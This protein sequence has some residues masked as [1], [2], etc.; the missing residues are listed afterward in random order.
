MTPSTRL[1][2]LASAIVLG[3]CVA[4][5]LAV[6][7]PEPGATGQPAPQLPE[8]PAITFP[9]TASPPGAPAAFPASASGRP[10]GPDVAGTGTP[11]SG[12]SPDAASKAELA[13]AAAASAAGDVAAAT[14]GWRRVITLAPA[15]AVGDRDAMEASRRLGFAALEAR[16]LRAGETWFAAEAIL[17]RRL[18]IAGQLPP[19]RLVDAVGRWAS[20]T[21]A[22]GRSTESDA[23]VR[24]SW[25][26]RDR[27]QAAASTTILKREA[28]DEESG[29]TDVRVNANPAVC[30]VGRE[31]LLAGRVSCQ[32]EAGALTEALSLRASQ[33]RAPAD[34]DA[35]ERREAAEKA[36]KS[37]KN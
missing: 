4:A 32:D 10:G 1:T 15:G 16:D 20:A 7:Q 18:F 19:R 27:T 24:Y 3:A 21:G 25:V 11:A 5:G 22:M 23:L 12:P 31:P 2:V 6:A 9:G 13:T 30:A 35:A 28:S 17:A 36:K 14:A 26:I 29:N 33:L 37:K 8:V 34:R